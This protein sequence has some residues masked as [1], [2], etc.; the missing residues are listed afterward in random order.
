MMNDKHKSLKKSLIIIIMPNLVKPV[1]N[2]LNVESPN[3]NQTKCPG[4]GN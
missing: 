1:I 3:N 2:R 4:P